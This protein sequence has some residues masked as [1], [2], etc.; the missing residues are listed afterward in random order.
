IQA[1][2]DQW[3]GTS[4]SSQWLTVF[5]QRDYL[6]NFITV[7]TLTMSGSSVT[8]NTQRLKPAWLGRIE[9]TGQQ[10]SCALAEGEE[11]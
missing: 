9:Q 4:S 3:L 11:A 8:V 10:S 1:N 6:E 5:Q 7:A 2:T